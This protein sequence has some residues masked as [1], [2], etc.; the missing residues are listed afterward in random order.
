M[1][2]QQGPPHVNNHTAT[3]DKIILNLTISGA[4]ERLMD[5]L[6][7]MNQVD[8]FAVLN[9]SFTARNRDNQPPR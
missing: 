9:G 8:G 2:Q 7:M 3:T 4:R 1:R 5:L 6:E